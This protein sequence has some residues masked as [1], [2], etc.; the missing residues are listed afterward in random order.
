MTEL[1]DAVLD[2][3][4][5]RGRYLLLRD[6][7]TYVE[8]YDD[9]ADGGVSVDR[10]EAY[11]EELNERGIHAF[12]QEEFHRLLEENIDDAEEWEGHDRVYDVDGRVSAFPKRWH[13]ELRGADEVMDFIELLAAD[14]TE[15]EG[16][17]E[18]GGGAGTGVPDQLL[19]DAAA[20]LGPF[21]RDQVKAEVERLRSEDKIEEMGDQHP[22]ARIWPTH[23][24]TT[25]D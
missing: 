16:T 24:E 4:S 6:L 7:V 9:E 23:M 10:L 22:E 5:E 2:A 13:E 25:K 18:T 3:A 11:V 17:T 1:D 15:H 20:A 21:H 14:I 8:R 19:Y 12:S